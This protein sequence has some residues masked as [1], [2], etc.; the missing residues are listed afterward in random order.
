[1]PK[2]CCAQAAT[3][4]IRN[5]PTHG[6]RHAQLVPLLFGL[7]R[8]Q[9]ATSP[10][11]NEC[12]DTI[13]ASARIERPPTYMAE[14]LEECRRVMRDHASLYLHCDPT[15]SHYL[16]IICDAVFGPRKHQN[17][18]GQTAKPTSV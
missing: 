9:S 5:R 17:P 16:K 15:A 12:R 11:P 13:K 8:R 2:C 1:M 10:E 7:D 3:S 18:W 14:R 4:V 6:E